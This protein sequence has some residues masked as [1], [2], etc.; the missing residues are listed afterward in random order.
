MTVSQHGGQNG[1]RAGRYSADSLPL[2]GGGRGCEGG[3]GCHLRPD[4]VAGGGFEPLQPAAI[5]HV[6]RA[7]KDSAVLL[8]SILQFQKGCGSQLNR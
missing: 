5:A 6:A 2:R 1:W 3:R 4:G 7:L 8:F